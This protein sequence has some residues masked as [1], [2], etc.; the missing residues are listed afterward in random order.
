MAEGFVLPGAKGET[1]R[2]A[3]VAD[4]EVSQSIVT[5]S[6]PAAFFYFSSESI[7]GLRHGEYF[8]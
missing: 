1:A 2:V 3:R 8:M 6:Y 7:C 5:T 4:A